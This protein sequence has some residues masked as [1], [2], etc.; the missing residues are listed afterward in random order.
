MTANC[1]RISIKA[2]GSSLGTSSAPIAEVISPSSP[3]RRPIAPLIWP[4]RSFSSA[5]NAAKAAPSLVAVGVPPTRGSQTSRVN[6]APPTPTAKTTAPSTNPPIHDPPP[7]S[8]A[9]GVAPGGGVAAR[10]ALAGPAGVV[11]EGRSVVRPF[12][13]DVSVAG[14]DPDP[15]LA[16]ADAGLS[17]AGFDGAALAAK[18]AADA[19]SCGLAAGGVAVGGVALGGVALGGVAL[20]PG[21]SPALASRSSVKSTPCSFA[22]ARMSAWRARG[23]VSRSFQP[24][25]VLTATPSLP[26]MGRMPPKSWMMSCA[27]VVFWSARS[28]S[29]LSLSVIAPRVPVTLAT[30]R[31]P[32]TIRAG[33]FRRRS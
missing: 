12:D 26:A 18:V 14:R 19:V 1:P 9:A 8:P 23:I 10:W 27:A 3:S 2:S 28:L 31:T 17:V 15:S 4:S 21:P 5:V 7:R 6:T 24:W 13:A 16:A 22:A 29:V 32:M 33:I 20:G 30:P 11:V 25:T